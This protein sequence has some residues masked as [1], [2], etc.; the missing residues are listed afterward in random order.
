MKINSKNF[1]V[2]CIFGCTLFA[3]ALTTVGCETLTIDAAGNK[4]KKKEASWF[5][6]KKKEYQSPQSVTATWSHDIL[7]LPGKPATRGF[8]GRFYF[9]NEKTQAIPVDGELVVY[10]F[11]DTNKQQSTE[12]LSQATK[13][14][15]FTPEQFTT[16]FSEGE[17]GAS[18][19]VWIPWDEAFGAPKKIMLIPT[20]LTKEGRTIRGAA[21]SLNLPGS[22][23]ESQVQQAAA[24]VPN[25][26]QT[27]AIAP[28]NSNAT[29]ENSGLRTTTIQVPSNSFI[30]HSHT[31][32]MS[33]NMTDFQSQQLA[34]ASHLVANSFG[35]NGPNYATNATQTG[36]EPFAQPAPANVSLGQPTNSP[37]PQN[38][39]PTKNTN[40]W[41]SPE[42][43]PMSWPAP[44]PRSSPS[45]FP[46][47]TSKGVQPSAYPPR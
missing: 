25:G 22:T 1:P 35:P 45:Q 42:F 7:T 21:A 14:F 10:G 19:S 40:G 6:F 28:P 46:A 30:R 11:D 36:V 39:S 24:F 15:R 18:Y 34:A 38:T 17:L 43:A 33:S 13:R 29:N 41:V 8:G 44:S 3:T 2:K 12:D 5:S 20:F 47:P 9:Y 37:S 16:H 4:R 26:G 31:A 23:K 32:D 27:S